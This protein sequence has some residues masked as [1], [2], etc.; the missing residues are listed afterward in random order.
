MVGATGIEPASAV[1]LLFYREAGQTN[2]PP[3]THIVAFRP[4]RGGRT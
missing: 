2:S 3:R 4:G 1:R